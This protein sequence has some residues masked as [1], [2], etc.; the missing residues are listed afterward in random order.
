MAAAVVLKLV[1]AAPGIFTRSLL[2]LARATRGRPA[3][4]VHGRVEHVALKKPGAAVGQVQHRLIFQVESSQPGVGKRAEQPV[5]VAGQ[6]V[7]PGT[8]GRQPGQV[9]HRPHGHLPV[10]LAEQLGSRGL[11]GRPSGT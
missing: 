6:V 3:G 2:R 4:V 1:T 8:F 11:F 9:A 10:A 7:N 5:V